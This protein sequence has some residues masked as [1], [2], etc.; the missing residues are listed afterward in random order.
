MKNTLKLRDIR[1]G[2]DGK[3]ITWGT[4]VAYFGE[5]NHT[6]VGKIHAHVKLHPG[7][8]FDEKVGR[9]LVYNILRRK[10]IAKVA[11]QA[12]STRRE[13]AL[14]V[15]ELT[16]LLQE[17]DEETKSLEESFKLI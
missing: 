8:V 4:A 1:Y 3:S 10:A 15:A 13:L 12:K 2:T 7:D 6:E 14:T 17:L 9:N 16:G 5:V 11:S